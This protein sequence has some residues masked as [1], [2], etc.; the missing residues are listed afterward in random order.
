[1]K[2]ITDFELSLAKR[3]E[4]IH[5]QIPVGSRI[6]SVSELYG[7]PRI[8]VLHEKD[9]KQTFD[10]VFHVVET[11]KD[12]VPE[13]DLTFLGTAIISNFHEYQVFQENVKPA[14]PEALVEDIPPPP[15]DHP[16][17]TSPAEE[18]SGDD[19]QE[20]TPSQKGKKS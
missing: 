4:P 13:G 1:M 3:K 9:E 16:Y 20:T 5:L 2:I 7:T 17:P 12:A 15:P 19:E 18:N 6:L 14:D 8:Y 11:R 10:A